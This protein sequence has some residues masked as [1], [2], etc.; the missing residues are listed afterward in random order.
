MIAVITVTFRSSGIISNLLNSV[1]AAVSQPYE[2]HIADNSLGSDV[3]L[4][5]VLVGYPS[6]LLHE[7]SENVGY[8]AAINA[9]TSTLNHDIEWIVVVNP[10][11]TFEPDSI[12]RLLASARLIPTGAAFGPRIVGA[13]G[14]VYPSARRQPSL[15]TGIGHA[16]LHKTWAGN[17]WSQRY[18]DDASSYQL[19]RATGWLSG[20]CLLLSREVFDT[21]NGFDERFFMYF[22][23]VD[24]GRRIALTGR[25]NIFVPSATVVHTG[26]HSTEQARTRMVR[27]HHNSAYLYLENRYSGWHLWPLRMILKAALYL[28]A[29]VIGGRQRNGM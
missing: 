5:P 3:N 26:A 20:A 17:P 15:R 23:D 7:M 14:E 2:I 13:N 19:E 18:L 22:E 29:R 1:P 8:G 4:Q 27:A 21:L 12:D 24:L 11:V 6:V 9:V 25:E 28:R 16:L 10:D